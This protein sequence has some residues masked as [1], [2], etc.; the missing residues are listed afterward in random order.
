VF[1]LQRPAYGSMRSACDVVGALLAV[2][3]ANSTVSLVRVA[4]P[5]CVGVVLTL[6]RQVLLVARALDVHIILPSTR[7][8][9]P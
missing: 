7:H 8:W 9:A 5:A 1:H 6:G 4:E 3:D 2:A